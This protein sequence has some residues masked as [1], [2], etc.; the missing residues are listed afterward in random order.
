MYL[1]CLMLNPR[2]RRAQREL[3]HPYELHRTVFSAFP[4]ALPPGERVL[5]RLDADPRMSLLALLVQS[6]YAPDWRWADDAL[7]YLLRPS[8]C[9]PFDLELTAGQMLAFRLRASP[10]VKKATHQEEPILSLGYVA[11]ARERRAQGQKKL[12]G[13][14]GIRLGLFKE[15]DQ[16]AWLNHK[17][18]LHGFCV[19]RALIMPEGLQVGVKPDEQEGERVHRSMAHLAVRYEGLLQVTDATLLREAVR[20]GIGSAKGFGFGLL[21]LGPARLAG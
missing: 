16:R 1:S 7:G 20:S 12:S 13:H 10:T 2:H 3:A 11:A 14:N 19:L 4:P 8:Q 17:G 21:S 6:Q 18:E 9:K 5:Y 15:D